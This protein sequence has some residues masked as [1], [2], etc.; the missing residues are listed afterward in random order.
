MQWCM[1]KPSVFLQGTR[2]SNL[3]TIRVSDDKSSARTGITFYLHLNWRALWHLAVG[4]Q[5]HQS[6][7]E[8]HLAADALGRAGGFGDQ[9]GQE[10][11][12]N[13]MPA[14]RADGVL[15]SPMRRSSPW[16]ALSRWPRWA[17]HAPM[18]GYTHTRA[19]G[20]HHGLCIVP[21]LLPRRTM[22]QCSFRRMNRFGWRTW[23]STIYF[24]AQSDL[25]PRRRYVST[26]SWEPTTLPFTSAHPR[27]RA[28]SPFRRS[29]RLCGHGAACG[30]APSPQ[31]ASQ[32]GPPYSSRAG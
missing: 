17:R 4:G 9:M 16:I 30:S 25:R 29:G 10:N 21:S 13:L 24:C 14:V 5:R 11:R 22:G 23:R 1:A 26:E 27:V 18:L 20:A 3:T 2:Y 7:R 28:G 12:Q 32:L 19:R 31:A 8:R 15:V 6:G